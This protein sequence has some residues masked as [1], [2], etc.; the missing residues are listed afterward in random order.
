MPPVHTFSH[1]SSCK[2][3]EQFLPAVDVKLAVQ[4]LDVR[5]QGVLRYAEGLRS[6]RPP[7]TGKQDCKNLGL[8]LGKPVIKGNLG[9]AETVGSNGRNGHRPADAGP[10][11]KP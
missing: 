5:T 11:E 7:M 8:P 9:N 2:A 1:P 3:V 4:L 6:A 10:D